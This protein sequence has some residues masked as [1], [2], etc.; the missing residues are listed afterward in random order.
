MDITMLLRAAFVVLLFARLCQ[1]F[2]VACPPLRTWSSRQCGNQEAHDRGRE[3]QFEAT[4]IALEGELPHECRFCSARFESRNAL[5]RHLRSSRDCSQKANEGEENLRFVRHSLRYDI[6]IRFSY[7][8]HDFELGDAVLPMAEFAG[9]IAKNNTISSIQTYAEEFIGSACEVEL[10]GSTQV[11]L[12]KMRRPC[13][14]QEKQCASVGGDVLTVGFRG[15]SSLVVLDEA[16]G[17]MEPN[18]QRDLLTFVLLET[19]KKLSKPQHGLKIRLNACKLLESGSRFHAERSCTQRVYQYLLPFRWLRDG[20]ELE[21]W[22][23]KHAKKYRDRNIRFEKRPPSDVLKVLKKALR[24]MESKKW[25]RADSSASDIKTS[26]GRFGSLGMK[27]K[28][29]W[30]NFADPNLQGEASPNTEPVWRVMDRARIAD[31]HRYTHNDTQQVFAVLEFRGDDFL[32][33]QVRRAVGTALAIANGFL[34]SEAVDKAMKADVVL[35]TILA[36]AENLLLADS[37]FHFHELGN[38][39]KGLFETD[40]EGIVVQEKETERSLDEVR[41]SIMANVAS[42]RIQ[43]SLWL[44]DVEKGE[45]HRM[46]AALSSPNLSGSMLSQEVTAHKAPS[47]YMETLVL[48]RQIVEQGRWPKTSVARSSVIK[49]DPERQ[50]SGSF[51][52]VNPQFRDGVFSKGIG[53]ECLPMANS[54]FPELVD[55]VFDLELALGSEE[56]DQAGGD[57]SQNATRPASSHCAIN[58]RAGRYCLHGKRCHQPP[59]DRARIHTSR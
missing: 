20:E 14:A 8:V 12:A 51:T 10:V 45:A 28:R 57:K 2:F 35:P 22:W 52:V 26:P 30:H 37:R 41:Y 59:N 34:P 7:W 31:F 33:Q 3:Q 42:R 21:Q 48:L 38:F 24:S 39:G 49:K 29:P 36:P 6:A 32:Q 15:P 11:T 23:L 25:A 58:S 50:S 56:R 47:S 46:I 54:L 53:V 55:A 19:N 40:T 9:E 13:L 5:F 16:S 44:R 18:R 1:S 43:S 27:E 17:R 4:E